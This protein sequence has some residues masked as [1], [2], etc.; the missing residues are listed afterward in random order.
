M[1]DET[2]RMQAEVVD[3]FSGPLKSLRAQLLDVSRQGASHG[4]ILAKGMGKAE[5]AIQ[6]TA[7][8]ATTILNPALATV[9]VTGLTAGAAV[10]GVAMSLNKL[11]SG[12]SSLGALSRETGVAAGT[13]QT[14][15]AVARKFGLEQDAVAAGTKTFAG[16]MREF[17]RGIGETYQWIN[18]Q[19]TDAAGRKAFQ[20]FAQDIRGTTDE[21]EKLRKSLTFLETIR[22]PVERG[23]FAQHVFGNSDFG[24]I[25][26]G[27]LGKL[28]DVWNAQKQRLGPLDPKA[29][30]QAEKFEQSIADLRTSM[31]TIGTTIAREV[32]PFASEFTQWVDSIAKDQRG[33]FVKGLRTGLQDIARE[34]NAI[35]WKSAGDSAKQM[36]LS[37]TALV[38]PLADD[39]KEIAAAIRSFNEGKYVEAFR[40]LDGGSGPLARKLAPL[41]GDDVLAKQDRLDQMKGQLQNFEAAQ[42][43]G[44]VSDRSREQA[45]RLRREMEKLTEEIRALRQKD[46]GDA[47]AQKSS[48]D[49]DGPFAGARIQSAAYTGG[50]AFG[51]L[52]GLGRGANLPGGGSGP[53]YRGEQGERDAA[54]EQFREHLKK[55]VPGYT[56]G[57]TVP[58]APGS[59]APDMPRLPG[60][61]GGEAG[62]TGNDGRRA[63]GS[64]MSGSGRENVASWM[65][66][67][68]RPT[69]QGGMGYTEEQARGQIAMMQGESGLNLN[70]AAKGDHDRSGVPHAFGTVQWSDAKGNQ[71]FPRLRALGAEMGKD[72]TD[73]SVQQE[74]YRREMM[75][76]YRRVYDRIR[77]AQTG[78]QSLWTGITG[79]E[80][81]REHSLA[82]GIRKPFLD[83]LRRQGVETPTA[84]TPGLPRPDVGKADGE[85]WAAREKARKAF[86]AMQ[87]GEGRLDAS[88]GRAGV[89]AGPKVEN[90][91]SVVVNVHKAGADA[92]VTTSTAGNL[93]RDVVQNHGRQMAKAD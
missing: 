15:G 48:A 67:F 61:G 64:R 34:L 27:H 37:T 78:E 33:D 42:K 63:A 1:A 60:L 19:G 70:S 31:Q 59:K 50:G 85:G 46:T 35:D 4:E 41:P 75:G 9:G 32:L 62:Y 25:A 80:N 66:F 40:H 91:G 8:S 84:R 11:S 24:R 36:L 38:K 20:D 28:A 44:P 3:R 52:P 87:Q 39:I 49:S 90:N 56:G 54:R 72:W 10:A 16:N 13:L 88:A 83:R 77:G 47:T 21:G 14:F 74:M 76:A 86:E 69:D 92:R 79:Y 2:L 71:R 89:V 17:S 7:R 81:P 23:I 65:E 30:L 6:T 51:R 29:I 45:D 58:L 93:F 5:S 55:T 68:R 53:G 26:D 82:F 73:R 43:I 18:R 57:N 12:L 22:N